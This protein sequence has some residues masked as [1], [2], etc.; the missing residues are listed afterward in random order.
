MEYFTSKKSKGFKFNRMYAGSFKD[1]KLKG[2]GELFMLDQDSQNHLEKGAIIDEKKLVY[3]PLFKGKFSDDDT[4]GIGQKIIYNR[5]L[6]L[7]PYLIITTNF[8]R[9]FTPKDSEFCLFTDT[10]MNIMC[11]G[12]YIKERSKRCTVNSGPFFGLVY[13]F[14]GNAIFCGEIKE[15][16]KF[17]G[18]G[19]RFIENDKLSGWEFRFGVW[20]KGEYKSKLNDEQV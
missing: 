9:E 8:G 15:N 2:W 13:D 18:Y 16:L 19:I 5:N 6:K 12:W 17:E 3:M 1:D 14:D 11:K 20:I 7:G 4:Y 10:K